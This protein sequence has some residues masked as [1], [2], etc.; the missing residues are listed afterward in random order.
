MLMIPCQGREKK[1]GSKTLKTSSRRRIGSAT[2][3]ARVP[4]QLWVSWIHEGGHKRDERP[5]VDA[6]G[7]A[8]MRGLNQYTEKEPFLICL[9]GAFGLI[10]S[11]RAV[12]YRKRKR[13]YILE[14]RW[15]LHCRIRRARRNPPGLEQRRRDIT[16]KG[17]T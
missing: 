6:A 1:G 17:I 5:R 7:P 3:A 9:R 11:C 4:L 12:E 16:T 10:T 13:M 14:G 8:R 15:A 2:A